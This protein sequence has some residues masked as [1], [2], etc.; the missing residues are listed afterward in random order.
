[1]AKRTR[2]GLWS[3]KSALSWAVVMTTGGSVNGRHVLSHSGTQIDLSL[4]DRVHGNTN[5]SQNPTAVA[6]RYM[7]QVPVPALKYVLTKVF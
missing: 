6:I 7:V 3:A 1:M 5:G 2:M 4:M